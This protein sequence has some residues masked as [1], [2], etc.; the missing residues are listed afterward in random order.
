MKQSL[1]DSTM[2]EVIQIFYASRFSGSPTMDVFVCITF[3]WEKLKVGVTLLNIILSSA[4]PCVI[5]NQPL[6][7]LYSLGCLITN[8]IRLP[9]FFN[10]ASCMLCNIKALCVRVCKGEQKHKSVS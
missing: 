3:L 7:V 8:L 9:Y 6:H 1:A 4:S 10:I 2:A 5:V